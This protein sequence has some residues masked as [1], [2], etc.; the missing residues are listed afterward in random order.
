MILLSL[1]TR[2]GDVAATLRGMV[3]ASVVAL[4]LI[5]PAPFLGVSGASADSLGVDLTAKSPQ[6]Q[7]KKVFVKVKTTTTIRLERIR[8]TGRIRAGGQTTYFE[9]N[10]A[11]GFKPGGTHTFSMRQNDPDDRRIVRKAMKR[12]KDLTAR[13]RGDFRTD[14]GETIVK[15]IQVDLVYQPPQD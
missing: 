13:M 11:V 2:P 9:P 8:V 3:F 15:K 6:V 1:G 7:G 4:S 10:R 12:G 14:G 5:V